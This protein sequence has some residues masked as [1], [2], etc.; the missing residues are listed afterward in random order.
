MTHPNARVICFDLGRVLVRICDDWR[1][2]CEQAGIPVPTGEFDS[3]ANE[4][5]M[6]AVIRSETGKIDIT[7]F[8]REAASYLRLE[9]DQVRAL[10]DAY[11]LGV[12]PGVSELL[13]DIHA[14][15]LLTACLTNTNENH[16]RILKE[17]RH[18]EFA[19]LDALDH[20]FASH[21]IGLRKPDTA[22]YDHVEKALSFS[23]EQIVFFDDLADNITAAADRGW[24]ARLIALDGDP[25]A[26]VRAHLKSLQVLA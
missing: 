23:G 20:Q 15:G 4:R 24:I 9:P 22:I 10:S 11:L 19:A 6:R 16:W 26:Q 5:I 8:S 12:Y 2:A 14:Q 21:L 1:H 13:A 7:G 18:E 17:A 3:T 25:V